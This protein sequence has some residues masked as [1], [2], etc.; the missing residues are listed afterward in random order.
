MNKKSQLYIITALFLV[1]LVY[2]LS[3]RTTR[4][5]ESS[6]D[7]SSISSNFLAEAKHVVNSGIYL[8]R[9][10]SGDLSTFTDEYIEFG[11]SKGIKMHIFYALAY[12]GKLYMAN[13]LNE[14]VNITTSTINFI[15][16]NSNS[17]IMAKKEWFNAEIGETDYLFNT[18]RN[19][20]EIKFV[21]K[22]SHE[23]FTDIRVNG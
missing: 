11:E 20:T 18:S 17:S 3:A 1:S 13:K 2:L 15:L 22:M 7:F 8:N 19:I 5:M 9:N 14:P 23:N 21:L 6:I 4:L 16:T 12:D 10:I